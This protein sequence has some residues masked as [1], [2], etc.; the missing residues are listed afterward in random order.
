M[1]VKYEIILEL[2]AQKDISFIRKTDKKSFVKLEKLLEE[3]QEHPYTGIGNPEQLK[4]ELN[5]F[6]SRR[7]NK[8]DWL[9]YKIDDIQI[10]VYI[11]SAKGHYNDK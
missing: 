10:T 9:L 4:H 5:G 8:K 7:I 1:K 6:W 3:L 2:K 11:V